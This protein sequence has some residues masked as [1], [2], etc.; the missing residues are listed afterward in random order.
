[1]KARRITYGTWS[2]WVTSAV[3][4]VNSRT[5][6]D[7]SVLPWASSRMSL[8]PELKTRGVPPSIALW[9]RL[10]PLARPVSICRLTN[11]GRPV[12]LA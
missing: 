5:I 11:E 7:R 10:I 2:A 6:S 1:M 12:A 3:Y 4:F 8:L 9:R